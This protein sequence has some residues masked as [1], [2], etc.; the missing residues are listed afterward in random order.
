MLKTKKGCGITFETFY[1]LDYPK[2]FTPNNDGFNDT[3]FIN[4]LEKEV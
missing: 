2:Y 1:I 3:W 4:N